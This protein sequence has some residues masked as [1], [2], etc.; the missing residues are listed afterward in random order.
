MRNPASE[1][2]F[3]TY[4]HARAGWSTS[5][6]TRAVPAADR[7]P[8]LPRVG[9]RP[10]RPPGRLRP[11]GGRGR[12]VGRRTASS[13]TSTC[14]R[15]RRGRASVGVRRARN[16]VV[17]TGPDAPPARRRRPRSGRVWH[18]RDLLPRARG[19]SP[20][21]EPRRSWSSAPGRAPP[22]SSTY[23][24]RAFPTRRGVRRVRPVRLHARPTTARS[25]TASSTPPPSTTSTPRRRR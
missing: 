13:R 24:H 9:R 19:S 16:V 17:G 21:A 4:L 1:F 7:V 12:P 22:R 15:P 10:A 6:T 5:S 8:R 23:L 11:R 20:P 25:P 3:L 14:H 2:S 18:N